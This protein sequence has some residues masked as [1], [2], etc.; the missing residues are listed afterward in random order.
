MFADSAAAFLKNLI[1]GKIIKLTF[2]RELYDYYG[3][4]LAYAWVL[5]VHGND[6]LFVQAELLKAGLARIFHYPKDNEILLHISEFEAD[7]QEKKARYMGDKVID[8]YQVVA[9]IISKNQFHVLDRKGLINRTR[10][11]NIKIK[12]EFIMLRS[13]MK[14]MEAVEYLSRKYLRSDLTINSIVYRRKRG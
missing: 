1:E 9:G 8:D 6:S 7:C 4:L 11:R 12:R 13:R 14:P 10:L 3:R 5:D 2:D